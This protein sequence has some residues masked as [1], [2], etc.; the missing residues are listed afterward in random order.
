M[1]SCGS[2]E[3]YLTVIDPRS[4]DLGLSFLVKRECKKC[5]KIS[6]EDW[7]K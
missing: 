6:I 1:C 7:S 5:G 3:F 2:I 4:W